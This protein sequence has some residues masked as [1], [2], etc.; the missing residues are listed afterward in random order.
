MQLIVN[1]DDFGLSYNSSRAI[2]NAF[3]NGIVSSTTVMANVSQARFSWNI[4]EKAVMDGLGVGVHLNLTFGKPLT[5]ALQ[6]QLHDGVF[7]KARPVLKQVDDLE[8]IYQELL[9]QVLKVQSHLSVEISH[10]DTHHHIQN[11]PVIFDLMVK[12]A[13]QWKVGLRCYND[14]QRE[15]ARKWQLATT[16]ELCV[17]FFD[18]PHISVNGL[19]AILDGLITRGYKSVE[20]M[21]HPGLCDP[22]LQMMSSYNVQRDKEYNT[23]TSSEVSNFVKQNNIEVISFY[24]LD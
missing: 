12:L 21:C 6:S 9:A 22:E 19:I 4:L 13:K 24:E 10:L 16:D 18:E 14:A 17:M 7:D 15:T 3:Y 1:A 2:V 20:L 8:L 11:N 23:L 5:P